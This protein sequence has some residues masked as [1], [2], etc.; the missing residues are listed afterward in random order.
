MSRL[1]AALP[2]AI[3]LAALPIHAQKKSVP[4]TITFSLA[5]RDTLGNVNV[6]LSPDGQKWLEKKV[7]KQYPNICYADQKANVG[8]WFYIS[9]ST[10]TADSA[11]ATTNT[12]P[13]GDGSSTRHTTVN[14][15]PVE[16]PIYT[17]K[18]GRF[19]D[20]NLEVLRTFQ[21]A[22][23][24]S[25]G[26]VVGLIASFSNPEHDVISDAVEWLSQTTL[27]QPNGSSPIPLQP[28]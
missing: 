5:E 8:I 3:G 19:H 16:Y 13:N 27:D 21:R 2:V 4:C 25:G 9:V 24:A 12:Y 7:L 10:Q 22:K 15:R 1:L 17:L 26:S 11:T 14:T 20:G 6:G 28:K 23:T 18:I